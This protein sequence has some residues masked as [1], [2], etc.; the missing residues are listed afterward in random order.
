MIVFKYLF[1]VS[2]TNHLIKCNG[3]TFLKADPNLSVNN[4]NNF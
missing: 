4:S 2:E 3:R 1:E